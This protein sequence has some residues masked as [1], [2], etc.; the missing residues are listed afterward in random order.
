MVVPAPRMKAYQAAAGLGPTSALGQT[1]TPARPLGMSAPPP[2]ADLT[3]A[4]RSGPFN[5]ISRHEGLSQSPC[6]R[7]AKSSPEPTA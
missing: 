6:L 2:I 7:A 3:K 5:G 4:T 1:E